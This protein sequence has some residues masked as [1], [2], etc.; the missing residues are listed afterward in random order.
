[1][2][3]QPPR[4]LGLMVGAVLIAWSVGI[5]ALLVLATGEQP[6]GLLTLGTSLGTTLC[7]EIGRAHV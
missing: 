4:A 1:M 2:F 3:Y 6:F 7:L 5:A